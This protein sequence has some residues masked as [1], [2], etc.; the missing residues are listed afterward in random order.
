MVDLNKSTNPESPLEGVSQWLEE[1][2]DLLYRFASSIARLVKEDYK[3]IIQQKYVLNN[4]P[5]IKNVKKYFAFGLFQIS[6]WRWNTKKGLYD[7][8]CSR[9]NP[10]LN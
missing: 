9:D 7:R 1:H 4:Y 10:E 8:A 6:V 5:R 2:G 3:I